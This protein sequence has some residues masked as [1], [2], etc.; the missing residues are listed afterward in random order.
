MYAIIG[1][2]TCTP[3]LPRSSLLSPV[4]IP[5]IVTTT[6]YLQVVPCRTTDMIV[7][8]TEL[9]G[10]TMTGTKAGKKIGIVV[11]K[12][13]ARMI[14][15]SEKKITIQPAAKH[16]APNSTVRP[17]RAQRHWLHRKPRV[18]AIS[19]ELGNMPTSSTGR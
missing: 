19:N 13:L 7:A 17:L 15:K 12:I 14:E 18:G 2:S 6:L 9:A 1:A 3:G 8:M 5:N 10:T 16:A 4:G 11:T